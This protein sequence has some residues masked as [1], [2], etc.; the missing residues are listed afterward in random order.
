MTLDTLDPPGRIAILGGGPIGI[1]AA[2]YARYL[3]YSVVLF[4]R[5]Q[6]AA[7]LLTESE[8]VPPA[9]CT[10]PLGLAAVAAQRGLGGTTVELEPES[11]EAWARDYF[12]RIA[13]SDLLS[14]R[15][16]T[17]TTVERLEWAPEDEDSED[18]EDADGG[19]SDEAEEL[20]E[21]DGPLPP[22]YLVHFVDSEGTAGVE[23]FEAVIDARGSEAAWIGP[24]DEPAGEPGGEPGAGEPLPAYLYRLGS[25]AAAGA[26]YHA[27]LVQIRELF[28]GLWGRPGL[29]VYA[30]LGGEI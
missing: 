11:C 17:A 8:G 4:E 10:S 21:D 7:R 12:L 23:R 18:S 25:R 19:G 24:G 5:D 29:D 20:A 27:G 3:G 13:E 15:I 28:A 9:I 6:L 1:E 26:D 16:R 14:G 2:L 30:N 22:D